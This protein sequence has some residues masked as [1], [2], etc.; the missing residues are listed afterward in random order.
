[1]YCIYKVSP[2]ITFLLSWHLVPP[3]VCTNPTLS[4]AFPS[5]VA[6]IFA[7]IVLHKFSGMPVALLDF[8]IEACFLEPIVKNK[9]KLGCTHS[10]PANLMRNIKQDQTKET[11]PS[12]VLLPFPWPFAPQFAIKDNNP[13]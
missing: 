9:G 5:C 6:Q 4:P 2:E 1:M 8:Q 3:A 11:H 13:A 10:P 12:S 7:Q